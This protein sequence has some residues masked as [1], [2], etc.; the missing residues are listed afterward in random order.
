M[1]TDQIADTVPDTRRAGRVTMICRSL[2]DPLAMLPELRGHRIGC[3]CVPEACHAE[4][5]AELADA[6]A[7]Q[8]GAET[9]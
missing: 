9:R 3:W 5:I 4:V 6:A 2:P 8:R 7:G 1:L